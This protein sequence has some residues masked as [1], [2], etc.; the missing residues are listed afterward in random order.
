MKL[1][2]TAALL[3]IVVLLGA[4][5]VAGCAANQAAIAV[6]T[7]P[8]AKPAESSQLANPASTNCIDKGGRLEIVKG[9]SGE[10]GM[11]V[12]SDGSRCE[13][14][15]FFR[16]ECRP[17][18]AKSAEN[19][20]LANPAAINCVDKGGRLQLVKDPSGESEVCVFADGT[21]CEEWAFFRG[22]C[23]PGATKPAVSPT[24]AEALT[25]INFDPGGTDYYT[26]GKLTPREIRG[27]VLRAA[28]GQQMSVYVSSP[29]DNVRLTISGAE[30]GQPLVRAASDATRWVG[31][32]T[33]SQDYVIKVVGPDTPTSFALTVSIPARISFASG[34]VTATV[35][36]KT[37]SVTTYLVSA[38]AGQ[39]LTAKVVAPGGDVRVSLVGFTDAALQDDA[40]ADP[41]LW[42]SKLPITQDYAITVLAMRPSEYELTVTIQ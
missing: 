1:R 36:G 13:E 40:P 34:A 39:T 10:S 3:S 25:R 19:S 17:G 26:D 42:V 14:W 20:Q 38:R 37:R 12:F 21:R 24:S 18:A 30:D 8:A 15:A 6:P 16:G 2:V 5:L 33:L 4:G 32:L 23:R 28:K 7:Q 31:D 9:Q 41:A 29:N 11:C 22:E 27:Y 35:K